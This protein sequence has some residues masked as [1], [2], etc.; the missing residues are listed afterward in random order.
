MIQVKI[1]N[2]EDEDDLQDAIN[3]YLSLHEEITFVDIHFTSDIY[4]DE[5]EIGYSF[6]A[7]LIYS[8]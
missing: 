1:W 8:S 2:E 5:D 4:E 7:M 3:S 6:S